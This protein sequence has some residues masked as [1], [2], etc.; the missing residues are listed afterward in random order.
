MIAYA[1]AEHVWQILSNYI[2][3]AF[4]YGAAPV[5]VSV[6]E[7]RRLGRAPRG[8]SRPRDPCRVRLRL[9]DC[10]SRGPGAPRQAEGAGLG[11]SIVRSLAEAAGGEAWYEPR[12]PAGA[13]FCLRVP[14]GLATSER[15]DATTT[16]PRM[17]AARA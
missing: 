4:K 12:E 7:R 17:T 2:E 5:E 1:D 16:P 6:S 13:C 10:F 9:F 3:N 14:S 11:L 15:Q 8:D